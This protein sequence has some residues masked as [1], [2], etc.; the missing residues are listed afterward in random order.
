LIRKGGI[1]MTNR[2]KYLIRAVLG[3]LTVGL[4]MIGAPK[5][6]PRMKARME[7]HCREMMTSFAE[8]EDKKREGE[9]I[10]R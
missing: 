4:I 1:D 10:F 7:A 6:V 5:A 2:S 3:A 8:A 9:P